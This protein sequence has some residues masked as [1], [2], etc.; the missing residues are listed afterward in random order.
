MSSDA[1]ALSELKT[2]ARGRILVL[3]GGREFQHRIASMGLGVGEEIEVL[4]NNSGAGE[5]GGVAV[6]AGD[7]RLVIGHGMADKII[8]RQ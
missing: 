3:R 2:G 4:Q 5:H 7:T 6:R 1:V 8:V